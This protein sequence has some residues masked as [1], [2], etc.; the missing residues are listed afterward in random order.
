M[1]GM[2]ILDG[3]ATRPR[4]SIGTN[5]MV[6][7]SQTARPTNTLASSNQS[8]APTPRA[9]R[10]SGAFTLLYPLDVSAAAITTRRTNSSSGIPSGI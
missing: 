2:L 5:E 4:P 7:A 6:V 8:T 9:K 10:S 1:A 3:R